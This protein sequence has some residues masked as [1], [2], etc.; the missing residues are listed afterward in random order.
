ME[1]RYLNL[2][3][4]LRNSGYHEAA[5]R[6]SAA[7]PAG[8]LDPRHYIELAK[9]AERGILD[10]IFLPDSPGVAEFRSEFL[11]GAGLDPLQLL[12]SVAT[13]TEQVGLIAT[14]S[15][16][17]SWPRWTSSATDG[18]AGTSSPPW[19]PPPRVTSATSRTP[20]RR[21][22]TTGPASTWRS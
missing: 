4:Y 21:T 2:N 15:T 18:P 10:S 22:A 14:A 7:D 19:S 11:P 5:W 8:V 1:R 3:V 20:R 17:Y 12:S 13:A 16:T 6:V 9:T